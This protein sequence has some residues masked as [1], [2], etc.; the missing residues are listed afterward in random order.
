[1]VKFSGQI[2]ANIKRELDAYA[3][4]SKQTLSTIYTDMAELFLRTKRVRAEVLRG[5]SAVIREDRE[6]L[7]RLAK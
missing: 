2:D 6:L 3:E 7:S 4:E 1:M 5:A